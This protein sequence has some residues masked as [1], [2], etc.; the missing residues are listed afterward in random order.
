MAEKHVLVLIHG[1]TPEKEPRPRDQYAPLID[2][3]QRAHL[4]IEPPICQVCWG[5]PNL[6]GSIES[7]DQ[8]LTPAE[9]F[10]GSLVADKALK[11]VE[12]AGVDWGIPGLRWGIREVREGV[13]QYGLSDAIYYAAPEGEKLVR[14]SVF[15]QVFRKL[16][17]SED[18]V[19][20]LHLVAHS[21]GVTVAH[22]FLYALFGQADP[23]YPSEQGGQIDLKDENQRLQDK[24]RAC[25]Q[26]G[27]LKLGSFVSYASQLPLFVMRKQALVK[28]LA[29]RERLDPRVIGIDPTRDRA[30]WAIFYDSDELLGFATRALYQDTP[31]IIDINVNSGL[32]PYRAHVGYWKKPT[33]IQQT[34]AF[35]R[36]NMA[37]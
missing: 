20:R 30:Q 22:D 35:L 23:H 9:A 37:G 26:A 25:A 3:L 10:V 8:Y 15:Q 21:L 24:W 7:E 1:I 11:D 28:Q 5:V 36:E 16:E 6:D 33:I 17:Q 2:A 31:A 32:D 12:R 4:P 27:R 29:R 34:I 14:D 13:V 18:G 19:M